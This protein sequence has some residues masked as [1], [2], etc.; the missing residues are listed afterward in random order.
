M[1]PERCC[2]KHHVCEGAQ[3]I[4]CR[5]RFVGNQKP[6]TRSSVSSRPLAPD[7]RFAAGRPIMGASSRSQKRRARD[8]GA[9]IGELPFISGTA[10]SQNPYPKPFSRNCPTDMEFRERQ[11]GYDRSSP[12]GPADDPSP[13]RPSRRLLAWLTRPRYLLSI[14]LEY[15]RPTV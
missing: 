10:L 12:R 4:R 8:W 9:S 3:S 2:S 13:A 5:S 1:H 6:S 7:H 14:P 15:R 11:D